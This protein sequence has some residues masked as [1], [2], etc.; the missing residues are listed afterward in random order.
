MRNRLSI[1][2]VVIQITALGCAGAPTADRT[3][4]AAVAKETVAVLEV[5]G[6]T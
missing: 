3:P 6:F 5:T 4:D 2:L 1:A